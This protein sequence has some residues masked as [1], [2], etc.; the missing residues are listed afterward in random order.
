MVNAILTG[1]IHRA[2]GELGYHVLEAMHGFHISSENETHY[3]MKSTCVKPESLPAGFL[4]SAET[5]KS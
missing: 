4:F 5:S 3:L 1:K 2:S